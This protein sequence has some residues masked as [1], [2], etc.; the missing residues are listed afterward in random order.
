M[1]NEGDQKMEISIIF[2]IVPLSLFKENIT[3]FKN[4]W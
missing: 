4:F 1:V 2:Q 3:I